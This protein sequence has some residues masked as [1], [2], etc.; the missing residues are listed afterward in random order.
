ME[1]RI[2][3]DEVETNYFITDKGEVYNEKTKK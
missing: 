1:K 2:I 3:I